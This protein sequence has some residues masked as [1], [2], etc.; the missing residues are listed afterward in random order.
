MQRTVT[1]GAVGVNGVV[2]RGNEMQEKATDLP[3][4]EKNAGED[5]DNSLQGASMRRALNQQVPK[6]LTPF[7]WQEWYAENGVPEQHRNPQKALSEGRCTI[8]RLLA[9]W[10]KRKR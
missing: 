3:S 9:W 5:I 6:T 8:R 1:Q 10:G 4:Q 2:L 7:E